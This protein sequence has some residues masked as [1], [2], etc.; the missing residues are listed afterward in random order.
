MLYCRHFRYYYCLHLQGE[1]TTQW[2]LLNMLIHVQKSVQTT[3]LDS[4]GED[5]QRYCL[6][7]FVCVCQPACLPAC[8][9]FRVVCGEVICVQNYGCTGSGSLSHGQSV[10][11]SRLRTHLGNH[12]QMLM[13]FQTVTSLVVLGRPEWREVGLLLVRQL[14]ESTKA[15]YIDGKVK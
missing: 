6:G 13:C 2:H 12:D 4:W 9:I 7:F 11:P 3:A 10:R 15:L 8:L 1:L 5:W 14:A